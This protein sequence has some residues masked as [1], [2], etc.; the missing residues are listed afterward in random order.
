MEEA[1]VIT[2]VFLLLAQKETNIHFTK[3]VTIAV[4]NAINLTDKKTSK[5]L[6]SSHQQRG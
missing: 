5:L 6:M 1:V 2:T 4:I 3:C